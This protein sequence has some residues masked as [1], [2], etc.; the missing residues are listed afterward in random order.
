MSS[1]VHIHTYPGAALSRQQ[2]AVLFVALIALVTLLLAA[3]ALLRSVDTATVISGNLAFRQSATTSGDGG[4]ES[5]IAWMKNINAANLGKDP[6][7]DT[8]NAFNADSKANGYY[9]SVSTDPAFLKDDDTWAD[10][11]S[12]LVGT[13]ASGNTVRYIIE[14]M[15]RTANQVLS[16]T[17]CLFSDIQSDTDSHKTGEPIPVKGGKR[18]LNRITVKISGPRNTVSYIQAF[19]Y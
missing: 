14:R 7:S 16:E 18:P 17:N 8:T 5:A 13:D 15:C 3:A 12:K 4:V 11:A 9:S 6:F 1:R 19:V 10:G 2:G